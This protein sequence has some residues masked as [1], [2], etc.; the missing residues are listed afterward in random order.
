MKL[1]LTLPLLLTLTLI[2]WAQTLSDSIHETEYQA[3]AVL[4]FVQES[5]R[6]DWSTT[7]Q[8]TLARRSMQDLVV[9]TVAFREATTRGDGSSVAAYDRLQ[10]ADAKWR[11]QR[12]ALAF[13]ETEHEF[14]DR[15]DF[16]LDYVSDTFL[17]ER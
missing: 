4:G 13:S 10:V 9:A 2:A 12:G 11:D 15:L 8:A 5:P 3:R 7:E 16:D 14:L 6:S 17:I 1:I